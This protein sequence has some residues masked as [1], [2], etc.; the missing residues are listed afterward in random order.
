MTPLTRLRRYTWWSVLAG[1]A[2]VLVGTALDLLANHYG[3]V[4]SLLVG[5]AVVVVVV[6]H[7]RYLRLAM[8]GLG[9]GGGRPWEHAAT[10]A[11]A[12]AAWAV[13]CAGGGFLAAWSLLPALVI[14]HVAASL[15]AGPRGG[16]GGGGGGRGG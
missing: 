8:D 15:P 16:A 9:R 13:M 2:V 12:L 4:K 10:F 14:A 5:A 3:L 7:T 11:V 1:G 6:Q